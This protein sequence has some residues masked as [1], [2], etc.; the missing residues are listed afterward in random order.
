MFPPSLGRVVFNATAFALTFASWAVWNA[1][2]WEVFAPLDGAFER[3]AVATSLLWAFLVGG[4]LSLVA[5][6]LLSRFSSNAALSIL[7]TVATLG[8]LVAHCSLNSDPL[9]RVPALVGVG[10]VGVGFYSL[11][12]RLYARTFRDL[13][14]PDRFPTIFVF[15]TVAYIAAQTFARSRFENSFAIS[16]TFTAILAVLA[17]VGP[18]S[19]DEA[20]RAAPS[21]SYFSLVRRNPLFW[22]TVF[23]ASGF[24]SSLWF[25]IFGRAYA[26]QFSNRLTLSPFPPPFFTVLHSLGEIVAILAAPWAI[27]L[28]GGPKRS[29][30]VALLASALSYAALN[31][32]AGALVVAALSS[33][34][35]YVGVIAVIPAFYVVKFY[36][37]EARR[38]ALTL[39]AVAT[40]VLPAFFTTAIFNVIERTSL[41]ANAPPVLELTALPTSILAFLAVFWLLRGAPVP[42]SPADDDAKDDA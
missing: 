28:C 1:S 23:V 7:A 3:R 8:A 5:N 25:P 18:R 35:A 17:L 26:E 34:I 33:R 22:A 14:N 38:Q 36:R 40:L 16:A 12:G 15:A 31:G 2:I 41:E 20:E 24:G 11:V 29:L 42:P 4:C 9:R 37:S 30:G 10:L 39:L 21:P 13:A 6:R 19:N 27:R 32:N